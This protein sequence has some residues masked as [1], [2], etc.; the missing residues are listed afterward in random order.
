LY[1]K[2]VVAFAIALV[3]V[4]YFAPRMTLQIV[5]SLT[6]NPRGVTYDHK[7]FIVLATVLI[8]LKLVKIFA[9]VLITNKAWLTLN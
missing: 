9:T 5:A 6:E 4:V 2:C 8:P 7:I 3:R 1:Y